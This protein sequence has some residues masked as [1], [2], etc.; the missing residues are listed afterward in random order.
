MQNIFALIGLGLILFV[1]YWRVFYLNRK[2]AIHFKTPKKFPKEWRKLLQENVHF[3]QNLNSKEKALFEK[4]ILH[5]FRNV[6]ITGVKIKVELLDRLFV[7][8]SAVIPLFA[9]PKW[10]YPNLNEV[11]LYPE[12]FDKS[13]DDK[14]PKKTIAGMVGTGN[15]MDN[16]M[17]L[18]RKSLRN[19]FQIVSSKKNVGIHE[20]VHIL[21]KADGTIDGQ[22]GSLNKTEFAKPWFELMEKEIEKIEANKSSID[23]YATTNKQEFL[24]VTSEYFFERPRL[25]KKNHPKIYKLLKKTFNQSMAKRMSSPFK[26]RNQIGRNDPCICGSGEKFKNCCLNN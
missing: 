13:F 3:Y 20:F 22:V 5:F 25:L 15:G 24:A 16:M 17:I 14:A 18:S 19:G 7:A 12:V 26:K 4:K 8:C 21:D 11:L 9:F 6:R 2:K 23:G 1:I 10:Q